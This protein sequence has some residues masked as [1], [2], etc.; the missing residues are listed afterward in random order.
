MFPVRAGTA[1]IP[2]QSVARV[3]GRKI[4]APMSKVRACSIWDSLFADVNNLS[5]F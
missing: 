4:S 5:D 1:K 3:P 2:D